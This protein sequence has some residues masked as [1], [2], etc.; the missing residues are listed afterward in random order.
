M[1][2][3]RTPPRAPVVIF[4]AA[5][6]PLES[7]SWLEPSDTM[8]LRRRR[9]FNLHTTLAPHPNLTPRV[10]HADN[11]ELEYTEHGVVSQG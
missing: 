2:K 9:S 11:R 1:K 8:I 10:T 5:P 3:I 4:L 7:I 6:A